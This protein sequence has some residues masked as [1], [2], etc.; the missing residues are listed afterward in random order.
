MVKSNVK[1]AITVVGLGKLGSPMAAIFAAKG[2]NVIGIDL[3]AEFVAAI[4][5][6]EAPVNEPGLQAAIDQGGPR[7]RA[8]TSFEEAIPAS[9]ASFI[10][11]PTPSGADHFFSN[12]FVIEAVENVGRALRTRRGYHLVVVTSTV[13]PGSTGGVIREALETASGRKIGSDLG[14][15]YSPEFIAL[16]SVIHDMLN[17]DMLLIG[18]S[19]SRA[20]ELLADI[21]AS[22]VETTPEVHR[23]N[24]V[25]AELCKISVNTFVTTK[26]SYA[27]MIAEMCDHLPTAD[28]DVVARAVG[29]DS[30]IGRKYLRGAIGYGGP[31]FPRDN[32]AF[33]ALG[34]RLGVRC[35]L[36]VATDVINDHQ[37]WRLVRFVEAHAPA[38]SKIAVLGMSYKPDTGVIEESQGVMLA[39]YLVKRGYRV[40]IADPRATENAAALLG[41]QVERAASAK[42]ALDTAQLA[43]ITTPWR[44]FRERSLWA[45]TARDLVIV[46][47]WRI[48]PH[49]ELRKTVTYVVP[50]SGRATPNISSIPDPATKVANA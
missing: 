48:V 43:V 17:P 9:D 34:H 18:E 5:A 41:N 38:T 23:M 44:E 15:C 11:V 50:G 39:N 30:R 21:Y 22:V 16:G 1:R 13:M 47:P 12:K 42:E 45:T 32:K 24:F 14:L 40:V 36:A 3:N 28:A 29:A 7:L 25:N 46:D 8:A 49:A 35:D 27:N 26:I 20:G 31:C 4:N 33:A 10:I 37:V 2:H 6:G 19:D